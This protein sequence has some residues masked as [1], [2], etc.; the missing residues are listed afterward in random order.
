MAVVTGAGR[1]RAPGQRRSLIGMAVAAVQARLEAKGRRSRLGELAVRVREHVP[2]V[3]ALAAADFGA[4]QV[5]HHGQG[6]F[7]VCASV[8]ALDWAVT[9][10]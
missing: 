3:A 5:W 6:W 8:L 10:R 2:T 1:G 7:V 4:F 9:G